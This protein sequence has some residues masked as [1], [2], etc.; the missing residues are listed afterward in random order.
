MGVGQTPEAWT[1]GGLGSLTEAEQ[2]ALLAASPKRLGRLVTLALMTG[3]RVGELLALRW[4]DVS[5]GG[6]DVPGDEERHH[7]APD[8]QPGDGGRLREDPAELALGLH[9]SADAR[10]LTP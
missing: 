9:E 4:E 2:A 5:D 1:T 8:D 10:S 7:A 3:A 6:I